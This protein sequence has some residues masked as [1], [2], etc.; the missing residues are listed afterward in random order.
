MDEK[1]M[2]LFAEHYDS[3]IKIAKKHASRMHV[4]IDMAENI[5][6]ERLIK[7]ANR[8]DKSDKTNTPFSG[9]VEKSVRLDIL[10]EKQ[11]KQKP[12]GELIEQ[13]KI[14]E[15]YDI[16]KSI[17]S[18][19]LIFDFK[20]RQVYEMRRS[21]KTYAEIG[22]LIGASKKRTQTIIERKSVHLKQIKDNIE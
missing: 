14:P 5:A 21:G 7:C 12:I 6:I 16:I 18:L 20:H 3:A 2:A 9:Y 8:G 11:R 19:S 10:H 4:D 17:P 22:A 1:A 13:V 15:S